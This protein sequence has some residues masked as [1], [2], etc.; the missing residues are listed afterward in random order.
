MNK[1]KVQQIA[2]YLEEKCLEGKALDRI[3]FQLHVY[4]AL[5]CRLINEIQEEN[6]FSFDEMKEKLLSGLKVLP[7]NE[8]CEKLIPEVIFRTYPKNPEKF[9]QCCWEILQKHL[10]QETLNNCV[11]LVMCNVSVLIWEAVVR[12]NYEC[13]CDNFFSLL[14]TIEEDMRPE[15]QASRKAKSRP[16]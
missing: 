5:L 1:E 3:I 13:M 15:F 10:H 6:V 9:S 11:C 2:D 12:K 14:K 8:D 16:D 7:E 4:I